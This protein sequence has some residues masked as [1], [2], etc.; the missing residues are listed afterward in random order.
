MPACCKVSICSSKPLRGSP[1]LQIPHAPLSPSLTTT[2]VNTSA[3]YQ[4]VFQGHGHSSIHPTPLGK[5]QSSF[6]RLVRKS[7]QGPATYWVVMKHHNK[8]TCASHS[9]AGGSYRQGSRSRWRGSA[10]LLSPHRKN[11]DHWAPAT[12]RICYGSL[13]FF[14]KVLRREWATFNYLGAQREKSCPRF[15]PKKRSGGSLPRCTPTTTVPSLPLS[16]P[17]ASGCERP[18]ILRSGILTALGC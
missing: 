2:S 10:G 16:T 11:V 8:A 15:S 18:S 3:P 5:E 13:R 1:N 7:V 14:T 12:M 6:D 17:A 4:P 9:H